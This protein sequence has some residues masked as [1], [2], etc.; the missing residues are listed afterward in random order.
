MVRSAPVSAQVPVVAEDPDEPVASVSVHRHTTEPPTVSVRVTLPVGDR[1]VLD[2]PV[3][4]TTQAC[5]APACTGLALGA[6]ESVDGLLATCWPPA[7]V[8]LAALK[9]PS[10]P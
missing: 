8:P 9:L 1:P 3:A 7:S 10:P 2:P 5:G 4:V 6:I